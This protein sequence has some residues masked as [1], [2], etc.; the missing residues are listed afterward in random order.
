MMEHWFTIDKIAASVFQK[1]FIFTG[2]YSSSERNII[3]Y[4]ISRRC[5]P[6]KQAN[7][8]AKSEILS[9]TLGL[10]VIL[11]ISFTLMEVLLCVY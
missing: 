1:I 8:K 10:S 9:R 5:M 6:L 2:L 11:R 7:I 4:E 3:A